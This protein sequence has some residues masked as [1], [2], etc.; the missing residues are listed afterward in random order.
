[1]SRSLRLLVLLVIVGSVSLRPCR[2]QVP[3]PKGNP[4]TSFTPPPDGTWVAD[5]EIEVEQAV[6]DLGLGAAQGASIR[7]GKVYAYGDLVLAKPRVGVIKEYS[8][9]L[10]PTGRVVMLTRNSR[11]VIVHPTG[12]TWDEK[13]GTFLGDTLKGKATIYRL[14]WAKAWAD[15]NLDHALLDTIED[16]AAVN[17]CR[18]VFVQVNGHNLMATADYGEVRPEVR[19]YDPEVLLAA[20]RSSAPGVVAYRFLCGPFNQNLAWDAATGRLTCVQN[21]IEGRGWRLDVLDLN[22]ALA[23]GRADGPGV[24]VSR[25]TFFSHDELEGFCVMPGAG[26]RGLFVAARRKDNL[27]IGSARAVE[28][29]PS[30]PAGKVPGA[31]GATSSA[32]P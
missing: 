28:P 32:S 4:S 24:R 6:T 5:A 22:K 13:Y 26:P 1:M 29:R 25:Q 15:G 3:L 20:H 10:K 14:D 2:A 18:P 23:D 7:D 12:L 11:P 9:D 17:G 19:L 21:V 31:V 27:V 30:P 16:D 8:L